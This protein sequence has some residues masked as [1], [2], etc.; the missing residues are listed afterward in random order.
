M[1]LN[2]GTL[3]QLIYEIELCYLLEWAG[4][5]LMRRLNLHQKDLKNTKEKI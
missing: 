5:R 2:R 1:E 3:T 4:E